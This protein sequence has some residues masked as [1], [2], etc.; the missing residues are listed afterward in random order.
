M[1]L[2][3]KKP[4]NIEQL[5]KQVSFGVKIWLEFNKDVPRNILGSGWANLLEKIYHKEGEHRRSLTQ[6][7]KECGYSYK[8]AWN[9]LKR[10]TTYFSC[11]C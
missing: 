2:Q 10:K 9:I 3:L 5:K 8:Y 1:D 11:L 4:A 7:A 6:A